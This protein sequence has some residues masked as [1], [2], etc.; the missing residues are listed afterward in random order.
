MVSACKDFRNSVWTL[1]TIEKALSQSALLWGRLSNGVMTR[2]KVAKR[3]SPSGVFRA[4][5]VG[6]VG[7]R[8][9]W[10]APCLPSAEDLDTRL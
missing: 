5:I 4:S 3:G 2:F 8:D 9:R 7:R 6:E 10:A 1:R